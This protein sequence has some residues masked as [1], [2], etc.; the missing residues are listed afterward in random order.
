[1]SVAV[2][3]VGLLSDLEIPVGLEPNSGASNSI[4][5]AGGRDIVLRR[6]FALELGVA[7]VLKCVE[8]LVGKGLPASRDASGLGFCVL[9]EAEIARLRVCLLRNRD[10]D[11]TGCAAL[12]P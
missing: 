5:V 2:L 1:M 6:R 9:C 8:F 10:E 7:K 12:A 11:L 3:N 4:D